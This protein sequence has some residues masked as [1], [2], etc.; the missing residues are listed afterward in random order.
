M[1]RLAVISSCPGAGKT[2]LARSLAATLGS[3]HVE[4]DAL[5]WGPLWTPVA[6]EEYRRRVAAAVAGERWVSDGNYRS[7]RDLLWPRADTL[8]WLDY[9]LRVAYPRLVRRTLARWRSGD[10]LWPGT[11]NRESFRLLFLSRDSILWWALRTYRGRRSRFE[12]DL[13]RPE[14]A[15]LSVIRVRT[16]DEAGAWLAE[17]SAERHA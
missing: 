5:Y 14:H 16:P 9:S 17:C 4:L 15:H 7:I 1:D 2:T 8:V 6:L 10:E 13:A 11:G 3:P 12:A